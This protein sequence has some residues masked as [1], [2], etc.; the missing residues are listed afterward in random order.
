MVIEKTGGLKAKGL[1]RIIIFSFSNDWVSDPSSLFSVWLQLKLTW[2]SW[3]CMGKELASRSGTT[4]EVGRSNG[5]SEPCE[6][7]SSDRSSG[8]SSV[9]VLPTSGVPLGEGSLA[10]PSS[11][12]DGFSELNVD[13]D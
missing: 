9:L 6:H 12:S 10:V 4:S 2:P 1:C 8:R 13:S 3:C 11:T 7:M 5:I